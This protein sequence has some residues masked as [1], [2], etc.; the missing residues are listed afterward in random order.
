VK[1]ASKNEGSPRAGKKRKKG[2]GDAGKAEDRLTPK[3]SLFVSAYLGEARFNATQAARVA[4][5]RGS[6]GVLNVTAHRLLRNP[7]VSAIVNGRINEAAMSSNEVLSRLSDI[8]RGKVTDVLDDDGKLDLGLAKQRGTVSLLKKVKSKRTSKK[9]DSISSDSD[10]HE[11]L[12]TALIYEEVEFEM[13][14]AHEALRDLGKYHKLFTEKME[15]SNPDGTP[16]LAPIANAV[17]KVYGT[18]SSRK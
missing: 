18:S 8:A 17:V 12:E 11:T 1:K 15:H 3:E 2:P 16:L 7:K 9:V 6:D 5:Y 13:Y 14:S 4:G 10:E